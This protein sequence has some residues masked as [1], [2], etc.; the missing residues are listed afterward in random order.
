MSNKHITLENITLENIKV[1]DG[2]VHMPEWNYNRLVE[3][4]NRHENLV[5]FQTHALFKAL[6]CLAQA[7]EYQERMMTANLIIR[8]VKDYKKK[9]RDAEIYNESLAAAVLDPNL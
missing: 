5:A 2:K 1:I 4:K 7:S 9:A 3:A 8:L 6:E